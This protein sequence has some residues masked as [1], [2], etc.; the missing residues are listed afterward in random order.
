MPTSK[1]HSWFTIT[2]SLF[3]A[4]LLSVWLNQHSLNRYWQQSYRTQSPLESLEVHTWWQTGRHIRQW[5]SSDEQSALE[6]PTLEL[7]DT[8]VE[9]VAQFPSE[10]P[11]PEPHLPPEEQ[12]LKYEIDVLMYDFVQRELSQIA[13]YDHNLQRPA[14]LKLS[15]SAQEAPVIAL[16]TTAPTEN[17]SSTAPETPS[18]EQ[19]ALSEVVASKP[20]VI[21]PLGKGDRVVFMGDSM[22][23]SLAPPI[24]RWLTQEHGISSTNLARHSTGLTNREYYDWPHEIEQWLREQNDPNIKLMVI[25]MGANDPWDIQDGKKVVK[26][27][28]PE[29]EAVYGGRMKSIIDSAHRRQIRVIWLGYPIMRSAKY[30][31]KIRYL[32]DFVLKTAEASGATPFS[33]QTL[34]SPKG[35]Y[36]DS[37]TVN[38]KMLR[39]RNK[40]GI[41]LSR[42]GDAYLAEHLQKAIIPNP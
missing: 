33:V 41:H 28:T 2:F 16:K 24:Q 7:M 40:D 15:T 18:V 36:Q 5:F 8:P 35:S 11:Q 6:N 19:S 42:E 22:M 1:P 29:W 32:N 13:Y 4:L 39:I 10:P 14:V 25:Q 20:P 31:K 21:S 9:Q 26:F 17:P 38:G 34:I 3:A 30:D 23:Q 27:Q 37:I 12:A